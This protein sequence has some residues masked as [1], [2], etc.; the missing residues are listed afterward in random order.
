VEGQP[1]TRYAPAGEALLTGGEHPSA[2]ALV[3]CEGVW[4]TFRLPYDRPYTLKQRVLHPHRSRAARKL[5]A[6]RD[7][8]FG[9]EPGEFFG[10]IGRNGSGKSTLLKCL[11][12]IYIPNRGEVA[13]KRRVSP[14]I[15]LG[16]GFNPELTAL[17]NVIV[18]A[19]LLGIPPSVARQRFPAI[20]R[21]AELEEFVDL[22][23]KNYSS[24]M[25]VRLG[26]AAAIQADADIYLVDEVL[27]VG[28]AHFQEKCFE[29]FR[30][31]KQTGKTVIFV[32]HDLNAVAEFCDRSLLLE[33]GEVAAIG[34]PGDVIQ[35]YRDH[36]AAEERAERARQAAEEQ[37][38]QRAP[39]AALVQHP[40]ALVEPEAFPTTPA[41]TTPSVGWKHFLYVT[42]TLSASEFKLRYF[43]SFLGYLWTFLRPM[44][45]FG[46]LYLVFT[47]I[48]KFG[49]DVPHYALMLLLGIV[50]HTF[51][52]DA[53]MSAL[54]SLVQRESLLRKVAFPRAAIPIAVSM[55]AVANL[56]LGLLVL[57][58]LALL[59]GVEPTASW[60]LVFPLLGILVVFAASIA[61]LIS[62]LFVRYRDVQPMWEVAVQLLFWAT[63]IIYM[64]SF[65]PPRFREV[66][67]SNP[68]AAV[69]Q[70]GRHSLIDA[71]EPSPAMVFGS[72]VDLL[73]PFGVVV[74]VA[75]MSLAVYRHL[76]SRIAEEL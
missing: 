44:I 36:D 64:I 52:A 5:D 7:V 3:A 63:P 41:S 14:F 37:D 42:A 20:I 29:V 70:Q 71:S 67:M 28:D 47:E 61:V 38:G 9:V 74:V 6:L 55:T 62:V 32:T 15:E 39:Q 10:V 49:G 1:E 57:L 18:N 65:V 46:V 35:T 16:V 24:G 56:V 11:A 27:A 40:A 68:L 8:T 72:R 69:I 2:D 21:F 76:A 23:L 51:F 30:R 59:D 45:A 17:D 53:T 48:F 58:G 26:F 54:P 75:L 25:F 33:R 12:G 19:S 73:I 22:K 60:L 4:K 34:H 50:L 66:V 43:G 13:V 31:M